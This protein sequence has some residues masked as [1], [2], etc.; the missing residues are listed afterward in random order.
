MATE[1]SRDLA[2]ELP[3]TS[4]KR[5]GSKPP[6]RSG[7][8]GRRRSAR[9]PAGDRHAPA[10]GQPNHRPA[11][12]AAERQLRKRRGA[13]DRICGH[14]AEHHHPLPGRC[15]AGRTA[16]RRQ[17][18]AV[19]DGAQ[20]GSESRRPRAADPARQRRAGAG[21]AQRPGGHRAAEPG[22]QPGLPTA[23]LHRARRPG[24]R[25]IRRAD[26]Q[27]PTPNIP[28]RRCAGRRAATT[29]GRRSSACSPTWPA[30]RHPV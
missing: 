20:A 8:C 3:S 5:R 7:R 2:E 29:S 25:R 23:D 18:G 21:R 12:L 16:E 1:T 11:E 30:R 22:A 13:A 17:D 28:A 9:S 10:A 15:W 14:R 4:V 26:F 6:D 19:V 24:H 27:G